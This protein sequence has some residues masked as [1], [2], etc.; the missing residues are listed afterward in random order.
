MTGM[1]VVCAG[2]ESS[3]EKSGESKAP[4]SRTESESES[5]S[6]SKQA[7]KP[8]SEG[9]QTG[10][11]AESESGESS[12]DSHGEAAM[13]VTS[14]AFAEGETIPKKYTCSG[15][16]LSPPLSWEGAPEATKS[17]VV[18]LKD[19][20]APSG[21]FKHWAA[22]DIPADQTSLSAGIGPEASALEQ[23]TNDFGNVGYGAPCPPPSHGA[24]RYQFFVWAL[25]VAS[26][27]VGDSPDFAAV[28]QAASEHKITG[29][30]LTGTF[31]REK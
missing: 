14:S 18:M 28:E 6:G 15:E 25:D 13:K 9:D 8:S 4:G 12:G 20:D 23:A 3:P 29:A 24:H 11:K 30:Q 22:Y 1:L 2:C 5:K 21:T 27:D 19:P 10:K 17:F 26:L 7:E 16:G 31:A